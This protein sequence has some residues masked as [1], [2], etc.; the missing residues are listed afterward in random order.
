MGCGNLWLGV[1]LMGHDASAL[2]KQSPL[3]AACS[4]CLFPQKPSRAP[5]DLVQEGGSWVLVGFH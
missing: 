3:M 2:Q 4:K 1:C 5:A